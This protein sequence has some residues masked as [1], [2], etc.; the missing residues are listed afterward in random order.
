MREK[1]G[2]AWNS[3]TIDV[4]MT[5]PCFEYSDRYP[6]VFAESTIFQ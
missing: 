3:D 5:L 6:W 4:F 1:M 2:L